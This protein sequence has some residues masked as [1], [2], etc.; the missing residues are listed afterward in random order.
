MTCPYCGVRVSFFNSFKITRWNNH[1][2]LNCGNESIATRVNIVL[3]VSCILVPLFSI[4]ML[5]SSLQQPLHEVLYIVLALFFSYTVHRY[6]GKLQKISQ[7]ELT[8]CLTAL[9]EIDKLNP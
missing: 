4:D 2:C 7:K 5:F 8:H 9:L 1:I 3:S 6:V